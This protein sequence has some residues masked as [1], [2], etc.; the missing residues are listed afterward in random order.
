L[1]LVIAP[2][3]EFIVSAQSFDGHSTLNRFTVEHA[4]L[5]VNSA[6]I[7]ASVCVIAFHSCIE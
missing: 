4:I 5:Y 7:A 2:D 1:S 3:I 6:L